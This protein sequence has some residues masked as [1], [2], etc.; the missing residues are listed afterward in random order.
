MELLGCHLD[1]DRAL[2][3][4]GIDRVLDEV[5]QHLLQQLLATGHDAGIGLDQLDAVAGFELGDDTLGN[6]IGGDGRQAFDRS[7]A[8]AR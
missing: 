6:V 5:N 2:G 8:I 3:L 7:R 1:E 4:A